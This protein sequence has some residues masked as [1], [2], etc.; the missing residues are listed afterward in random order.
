VL[1]EFKADSCIFISDG[2]SDEEVLPIIESRVKI[3]SKKTVVMKQAKEL[4]KTYFVILEKL[5]EPYYAQIIFGIPA[6]I[7]LALVVGDYLGVGWKLLA[8]LL[9]GY[10]LIK[11][12]GIDYRLSDLFE[13]KISVEKISFIAYLAALPIFV[14][15]LW[16]GA[17]AYTRAAPLGIDA[18]KISALVIRG[19]LVL[20]PW[21]ALLVIIGRVVDLLQERKKYEVVRQGMYMVTVMLLWLLFSVASDWVLAD[22]Y[23]QEF[24]LTIAASIVIA[25]ASLEVL[26]RLRIMIAASMKLENKE[27][28]SEIGAYIGKIVGVDRKRGQLV[29]QTAFGQR[30]TLALD[31]VV[32]VGDKVTVRY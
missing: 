28:L 8:L 13:L 29:I 30:V 7:L 14:I 10:L 6:F 15:S 3:D 27:A 31:S 4:E 9:G 22:A 5:R 2:A 25:F 21:A 1:S 18:V 19:L 26:R 12:F 20:L 11:G 23:F 32:N 24:V 16:L 17:Q